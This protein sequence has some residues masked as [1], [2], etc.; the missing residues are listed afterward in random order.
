MLTEPETVSATTVLSYFM[1]NIS[2]KIVPRPPSQPS[3]P[4]HTMTMAPPFE[5]YTRPNINAISSSSSSSSTDSSTDTLT[6]QPEPGPAVQTPR[7]P[8]LR[9]S[10]TSTVGSNRRYSS[11]SSSVP[12]I[13]IQPPVF[14]SLFISTSSADNASLVPPRVCWYGEDNDDHTSIRA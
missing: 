4:T 14:S 11:G 9:R 2:P 3:T 12:G 10:S 8:E 6:G 5:G 1:V 13:I 7:M